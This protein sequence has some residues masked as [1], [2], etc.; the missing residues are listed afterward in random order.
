MYPAGASR[1]EG[2]KVQ[3]KERG[4]RENTDRVS[5]SISGQSSANFGACQIHPYS[6]TRIP[7]SSP[8]R[9][10]AKTDVARDR[11]ILY[12]FVFFLS[13]SLSLSLILSF[14]DVTSFYTRIECQFSLF[15]FP[16]SLISSCLCI[17][18]NPRGILQ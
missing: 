17:T 14:F 13:P 16:I 4:K 10:T 5:A 18:K 2:P 8:S 12:S 7:P 9:S 1:P 6:T 15:P 11:T 3:R